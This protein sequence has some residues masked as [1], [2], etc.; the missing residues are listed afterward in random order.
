V[1]LNLYL[2]QQGIVSVGDINTV[3]ADAPGLRLSGGAGGIAHVLEH[4]GSS[5][6]T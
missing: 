5:L 3:V 4:L 1:P 2:V 6:E